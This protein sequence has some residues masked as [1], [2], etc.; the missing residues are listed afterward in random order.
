MRYYI[1][2]KRYLHLQVPNF[3]H[4]HKFKSVMEEDPK[5]HKEIES[6]HISK[7]CNNNKPYIQVKLEIE[8]RNYCTM[9]HT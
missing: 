4:I 1:F 3:D 6:Q 9:K 7:L 8:T 5:V 2:T